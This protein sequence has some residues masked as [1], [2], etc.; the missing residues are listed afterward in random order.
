MIAMD[1]GLRNRRFRLYDH[2]N[3]LPLSADERT[4]VQEAIVDG[5]EQYVGNVMHA[6][7]EADMMPREAWVL[8]GL[9]AP[10]DPGERAARLTD[11]V[12]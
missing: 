2:L 8:R 4:A 3:A 6:L 5:D 10:R 12:A 1:R 7:R 11:G 9:P